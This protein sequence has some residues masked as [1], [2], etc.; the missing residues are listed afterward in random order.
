[1]TLRLP[2]RRPTTARM[3][4]RV[5]R[6]SLGLLVSSCCS[7][8]SA[9]QDPVAGP[10]YQHDVANAKVQ[11]PGRSAG[12][13]RLRPVPKERSQFEKRLPAE[14]GPRRPGWNLKWRASSRVGAQTTAHA[15]GNDPVAD[16]AGGQT[17][18]HHMLENRLR[19]QSVNQPPP[20]VSRVSWEAKHAPA[21]AADGARLRSQSP[22]PSGDAVDFFRDPFAEVPREAP[23]RRAASSSVRV[24]SG[25]VRERQQSHGPSLG[26]LI[27]TN[28]P[29]HQ[30]PNHDESFVVQASE[31]SADS[32]QREQTQPPSPSDRS[33]PPQ[34]DRRSSS[35]GR[36][37]QPRQ[38]GE[39]PFDVGL[40]P[41]PGGLSC[42]EFREKIRERTIRDVSLDISP[43]F[44]P[45]IN[46]QETYEQTI[47]EFR[48]A[49]PIRDWRTVD[50]RE[51]ASGRLL[52]LAFEQVV[53]E[54]E[55]GATERLP[56]SRLSESDLAYL[57]A[58]W[59]LPAECVNPQV[60]Y[61]PRSWQPMA[62]TWAA[63]NL[64]HKPLYFQEVNLERY[65]HTAGPV[66]Q[67]VISSAHFFANI[68]VLPYKMGVHPPTECQ[69]TLGYYRP[70]NCAPW[71]LPPVPLSLRGGLSQA[72]VMTG[73]FWLIP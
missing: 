10:Q 34:Q 56:V 13:P 21:P 5:S 49:Q 24:D 8:H 19:R 25:P 31:P 6:L 54:T 39:T 59:G 29:Q 44:R 55:Y 51:L 61:T 15:A 65:G 48:D 16:D 46:D 32:G 58:N 27:R 52:D 30:T 35:D 67:P 60:A 14:V 2:K 22:S 45:D 4:N 33:V 7:L 9:A 68:A 41:T 42:D 43:P 50:G 1:M 36:P 17:L 47:A 72:A 12:S 70:G 3:F 53:I 28:L 73:A 37:P 23:T 66:L 63:S 38:Q 57:S 20:S 26:E 40:Q 69:Y 62:V 11:P 71:I 64:C 18:Q